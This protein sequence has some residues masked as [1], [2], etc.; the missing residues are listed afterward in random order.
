MGKIKISADIILSILK[1]MMEDEEINYVI[2]DISAPDN[3][4][5]KTV[6]E[7]LNIEYYTFRHRPF[8]TEEVIRELV[9][10]GKSPNSLFALSRSFCLLSLSPPQRV[11]SKDNDIVTVSA[12]L[13]YWI[14]TEKVKLL[15]DLIEDL[16]VE[17]TG[18]RIPVQI[19][20]EARR[21]VV[22]FGGIE[23]TDVQETTEFGEMSVCDLNV[24]F[25]FYPNSMCRSD[26]TVEFLIEGKWVK[27]PFAS[28]SV[29]N[30]MTQ[31]AVPYANR[32]RSVG[33]INLSKVRTVVLAFDGYINSFVDKLASQSLA[34]DFVPEGEVMEELDN[35]EQIILKLTRGEEEF[36]YAC[37][38]KDHLITVQEDTGN[39]IHSLTLTTRG[40]KNGSS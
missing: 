21:A 1:G 19:G 18:I 13:E 23:V 31:K 24:D 26:Y 6:K 7:A 3:W 39:E 36:M 38:I 14:Q 35:N 33:I 10:Q 11:F 5:G 17:A 15:E 8:N 28:L 30:S 32:V 2:N 9:N 22:V 37:V 25:I 27:L 40:M 29:S 20:K 16:T 34:S 12:N 4:K